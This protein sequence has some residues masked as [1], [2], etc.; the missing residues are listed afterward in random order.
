METD[1]ILPVSFRIVRPQSLLLEAVESISGLVKGNSMALEPSPDRWSKYE[2]ISTAMSGAPQIG[3]R[4]PFP[5]EPWAP[6]P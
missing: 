6:P 1:Q 4:F 3:S 2:L 5:L